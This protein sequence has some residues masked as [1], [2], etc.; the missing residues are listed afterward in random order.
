ME[1]GITRELRKLWN[2]CARQKKTRSAEIITTKSGWITEKVI[3][4]DFV[5]GASAENRP[6]TQS[7]YVFELMINY[8]NYTPLPIQKQ[9]LLSRLSSEA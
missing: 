2:I 1:P 6:L 9:V 8:P 7:C 5:F 4:P 3:Q